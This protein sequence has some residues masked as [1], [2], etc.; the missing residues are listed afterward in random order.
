MKGRESLPSPEFDRERLK[1]LNENLKNLSGSSGALEGDMRY[2]D[3]DEKFLEAILNDP[4]MQQ[5][6]TAL[7][8]VVSEAHGRI[9]GM[10]RSISSKLAHAH[11]NSQPLPDD[12]RG[13]MS[14][15]ISRQKRDQMIAERKSYFDKTVHWLISAEFKKW[16]APHAHAFIDF[17]QELSKYC[18]NEGEQ[19]REMMSHTLITQ[20]GTDIATMKRAVAQLETIYDPNG[21]VATYREA[22]GRAVQFFQ[23]V[24]TPFIEDMTYK[25]DI[26]KKFALSTVAYLTQ[27]AEEIETGR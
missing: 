27:S 22:A 7:E 9:S 4:A 24:L 20:C 25:D 11:A 21:E 12:V 19:F 2:V 16:I 17:N 26:S 1:K 18:A 10:F 14:G 13:G 23:N 5:Q 3:N 8:E 6:F 15:K